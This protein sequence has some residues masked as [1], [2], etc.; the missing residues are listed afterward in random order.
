M[1]LDILGVIGFKYSI[2]GLMEQDDDGHDLAPIHLGR[3][4]ALSLPRCQ[5]CLLPVQSELLPEIVRRTKQF[6]YTHKRN[7]LV[8][9]TDVLFVLSYQERLLI[10][11]SR[12]FYADL[13]GENMY[14]SHSNDR[15][16]ISTYL[17]KEQKLVSTAHM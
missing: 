15:I 9:D 17:M 8:R 16:S 3:A 2:V 4:Q 5:H 11:N 1:A 7:L 6:E 13:N 10:S 14:G 12:Y